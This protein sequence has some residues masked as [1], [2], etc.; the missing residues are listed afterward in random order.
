MSGQPPTTKTQTILQQDQAQLW[1]QQHCCGSRTRWWTHQIFPSQALR[2]VSTPWEESWWTPSRLSSFRYCSQMVSGTSQ[3]R[4]WGPVCGTTNKTLLT[5]SWHNFD[6]LSFDGWCCKDGAGWGGS[7]KNPGG[8][9]HPNICSI[10]SLRRHIILTLIR[11]KKKYS[12]RNIQTD[13]SGF[14]P[15]MFYPLASLSFVWYFPL[16]RSIDRLNF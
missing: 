9:K 6:R 4:C 15:A 3:N 12:S 10:L 11:N 5:S 14:H 13:W 16:V 2:S 1:P 8:C 7:V